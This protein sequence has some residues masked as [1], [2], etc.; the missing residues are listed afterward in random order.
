VASAWDRLPASRRAGA[1]IV[2]SNYGEAGAID[3]FG[4]ALGLPP[5]TSGHNGYWFWARDQRP[6]A[7]LVV[8]GFPVEQLADLCQGA[9]QVATLDNPYRVANEERGQPVVVCPSSRMP[10]RAWPPL[11]RFG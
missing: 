1:A 7:P 5:A 11:R 10:L 6:G 2:A 8:V 3:R 4:P 9:R